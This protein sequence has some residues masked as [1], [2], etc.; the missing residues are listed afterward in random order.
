MCAWRLRKWICCSV[1]GI[2]K[3]KVLG[4]KKGKSLLAMLQEK[5]FEKREE[6]LNV[7]RVL[8][9]VVLCW[10]LA[11]GIQS[12]AKRKKSDSGG[13]CKVRL[14]PQYFFSVCCRNC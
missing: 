3:S 12:G 14:G 7:N 10:R 5:M 1:G 2:L 8:C 11:M 9:C 6:C 13:H 4:G